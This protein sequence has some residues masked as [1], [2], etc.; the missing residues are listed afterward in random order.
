V[1]A[2]HG[3]YNRGEPY[4]GRGL[5]LLEP[6]PADNLFGDPLAYLAAQSLFDRVERLYL[7]M[8]ELHETMF[9]A[10]HPLV[11]EDVFNLA[12][13]YLV[14]G[15][16]DRAEPLLRRWL[17][18]GEAVL[19]ADHPYMADSLFN[20]AQLLIVRNRAPEAV[21]FLDRG[22]GIW[23][24]RLR[25]ETF[26][27]SASR[28]SSFLHLFRGDE[29]MLYQIARVHPD[30]A[31][32]RKLALTAALLLKGRSLEEVAATAGAI[33]QSLSAGDA[34][35][36][37]R[38]RAL[39]TRFAELALDGPGPT[40]P[41]EH[42]QHL[43]DLAAQ[44]EALEADLARRS[45]PLRALASLPPA[46]Q[47]ASQVAAGLPAG[48]ALVE[49]VEYNNRRLE[50]RPTRTSA[51]E[52][53]YLALVLFPDGR[54]AA[55]DLGPAAAIDRAVAHLRDALSRKKV[56]YL[57]KARALH[58]LVMRPL[59]PLLGGTRRLVI[60]PDGQLS[61]VPFAAL[62]DGQRFLLDVFDIAYVTSGKDLLP[63]SA[64]LGAGRPISSESAV[65]VMADPDYGPPPPA[66]KGT[67]SA[68]GA[69]PGTR[70]EAELIREL[71]PRDTRLFLGARARKDVLL[72]LGAPALLHLGA[73]AV[74]LGESPLSAG[75]RA[76]VAPGEGPPALPPDPLLRSLV[77]LSSP[78]GAAEDPGAVGAGMVTALELAG[79]DLWGTQLVV[80]SA[81]DTGVG[82]VKLGQGVYGLRR[83]LFI[84][85]AETV[86]MSLWHV[87]DDA[88]SALMQRYYQNL[89]AARGRTTALQEAMRFVRE[90]QPHPYYWA[91]FIASGRDAPLSLP[92][93]PP[94]PG[95]R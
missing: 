17:A 91:G 66:G 64:E 73:H 89:A 69:L 61:L 36:L 62:H 3:L 84:A 5:A 15:K 8:I 90:K 55:A 68:W 34:A 18:I 24:K 45:A 12:G 82:E 21:P 41:E 28:M 85:G 46:E 51:P 78:P 75:D 7:R 83:A 56:A 94:S 31:R 30:N 95:S 58:D 43:R 53:R 1:Y 29:E 9:G 2:E 92:A 37:G 74:F 23:E 57:P 47:I 67:R 88:T 33:S 93:H 19:G 22:L 32:V 72:R 48:S 13:L 11:A 60:A 80:L 42:R 79:M 77:A 50:P 10:S 76:V 44:C 54:T 16:Y 70:R 81:C 39:R 40:A 87:N 14:R 49:M 63:R 52:L 59:M 20:L 71:F 25:E 27:F 65:V 35:A 6:G 26:D 38:L 86:V 4:H